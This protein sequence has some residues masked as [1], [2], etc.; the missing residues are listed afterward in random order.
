MRS[1]CRGSGP[2]RVPGSRPSLRDGGA[3][4]R[5]LD[6]REALRVLGGV[7]VVGPHDDR[8]LVRLDVVAIADPGRPQPEA[9]VERLRAPVACPHPAGE[10]LGPLVYAAPGEGRQP[11]GAELLAV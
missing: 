7:D 9:L 6:G 3:G 1:R 10:V 4:Q 2:A 5:A 8:V 11:P